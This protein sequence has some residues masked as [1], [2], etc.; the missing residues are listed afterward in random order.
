VVFTPAT[1][2]G[3]PAER[4]TVIRDA[5]EGAGVEVLWRQ[6]TA[7]DPGA[8][9]AAEAVEAGIDLLLACGGDGT[10]TGCAAAVTGTDV[11]L[12]VL[13]CGTGNLLA[14][15]FGIPRDVGA[16]IEVALHGDRRRIDVGTIGAE[17]FVVMSGLGFDA[18]M[19]RD[20]DPNLKARFGALAYVLS[21]LSHL[22]RRPTSFR[23]QLD[24]RLPIMRRGQGVLI[25]NVGRLQGRLPVLPD[26]EP[27]DGLLDVAVLATRTLRDWLR[28]A[29]RVAVLRRRAPTQLETW[30]AR[31]VEVRCERPQ[32]MERDG[33]YGQPT[34]SVVAEV[35]PR[36]L[37][38]CV[39]RTDPKEA[40]R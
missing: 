3:D 23:I 9:A 13:P 14:A 24:Q 8:G 6:T 7:T 40:V 29:L 19:L 28:L 22:R 2:S 34:T 30:Q 21:A 11:P 12:G 31:R 15:N 17:R 32:P 18:E 5:L 35:L 27:D 37:T 25:G 39:P 26:A 33:E 10:L 38:L 1:G 36:A 4:A 20:A 16:A